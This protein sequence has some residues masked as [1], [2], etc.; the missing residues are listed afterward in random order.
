MTRALSPR[1]VTFPFHYIGNREIAISPVEISLHRKVPS[2]EPRFL[3]IFDTCSHSDR[4][5]QLYRGIAIRDFKEYETPACA[6]PD[7]P[8]CDDPWF[9]LRLRVKPFATSPQSDGR[10]DFVNLP[11]EP[12][13]S[14]LLLGYFSLHSDLPPIEP[15]PGSI[16]TI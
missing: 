1:Y 2:V 10:R 9:L 5:L 15:P 7:I 8:I 13:P 16:S 12:W 11:C 6:N 4:R 14:I 3:R